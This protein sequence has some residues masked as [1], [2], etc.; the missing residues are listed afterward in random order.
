MNDEQAIQRVEEQFGI[1]T[2]RQSFEEKLQSLALK[3]NDLLN[4]DFQKLISLLYRMDINESKLRRLLE[5]NKNTDAGLI[6]A[7]MM[8]EREAQKIKSRKESSKKNNQDSSEEK[9]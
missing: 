3:I 4:N 8:I 7:K 1:I 9:W 6:I 2:S 5:E